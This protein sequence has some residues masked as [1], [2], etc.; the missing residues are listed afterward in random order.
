MKE[1]LG[2]TEIRKH[3]NRMTFAEVGTESVQIRSQRLG[4]M[5]KIGYLS[6]Y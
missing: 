2:L 5:I 1:R 3:A 6:E 4:L